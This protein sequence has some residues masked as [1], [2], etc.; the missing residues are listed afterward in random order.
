M[1]Y[2]LLKRY[3]EQVANLLPRSSKWDN[4]NIH[5]NGTET[6]KELENYPPDILD[7]DTAIRSMRNNKAPDIDNIPIKL[8]KQGGQ[9]LINMLHSLI[10]RIWI[11]VE[12]PVE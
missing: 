3:K 7:T 2:Y 1:R 10:K 6:E 8:N 11:T 5:T 4:N 9:L 12:V